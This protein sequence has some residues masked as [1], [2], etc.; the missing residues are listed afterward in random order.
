MKDYR[1]IPKEN[2]AFGLVLEYNKL[3]YYLL[4]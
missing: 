1:Q 2:L 3:N 4:S